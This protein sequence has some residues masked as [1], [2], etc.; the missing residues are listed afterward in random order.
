MNSLEKYIKDNKGQFDEEPAKGHFERLQ[1]KMTRRS[2][3]KRIAAIRWGMSIAA[4]I[5]ILFIAGAIFLRTDT[6]QEQFVVCETSSDM[7]ICYME[8]ITVLASRIEEL[9]VDFDYW[10]RQEVMGDVLYIIETVS[11]DFDSEIAE[12]VPEAMAK[13]ILSEFY[14]QN[15]EGME[16]IEEKVKGD[17]IRV[18]GFGF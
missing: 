17:G 8:K 12:E 3:E 11:G 5:A 4:S 9:V 7:K 1:Q 15:L 14:R 6:T 16:M 2:S 13:E 18:S 10:D